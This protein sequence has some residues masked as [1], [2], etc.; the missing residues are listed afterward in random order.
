MAA[1]AENKK[2]DLETARVRRR[3]ARA[4]AKGAEKEEATQ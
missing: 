3:Y 2:H 1:R 4:L